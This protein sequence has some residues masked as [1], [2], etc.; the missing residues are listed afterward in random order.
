MTWEAATWCG[1]GA[2]GQGPFRR[3]SP[4]IRSPAEALGRR[5]GSSRSWSAPSG[6]SASRWTRPRRPSAAASDRDGVDSCRCHAARLRAFGSATTS[7]VCTTC[8]ASPKQTL[9]C[10]SVSAVRT[11]TH[12]S[13]ADDVLGSSRAVTSHVAL[14]YTAPIVVG[15]NRCGRAQPPPRSDR[16][17]RTPRR[18]LPPPTPAS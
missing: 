17:G 7:V 8:R 2:T 14:R 12:H 6:I 9:R 1:C 16:C 15:A 4:L 3:V 13:R 5:C 10:P 11:A 18:P